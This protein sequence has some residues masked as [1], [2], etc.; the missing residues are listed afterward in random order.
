M[1]A[2]DQCAVV[3]QYLCAIR[4]MKNLVKPG[5]NDIGGIIS[6]PSSSTALLMSKVATM[7]AIT[8]HRVSSAKRRPGHTLRM[9]RQ[10]GTHI[11]V[12]RFIPSPEREHVFFGIQFCAETSTGGNEA[13]RTEDVWVRVIIGVVAHL[14][15]G[16]QHGYLLSVS[17]LHT[18]DLL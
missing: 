3:S 4:S 11:I 14:P 2:S 17:W 15:M 8:S 6:F 13:L 5:E 18:R 1:A 7:L 9:I 16:N 12:A 10:N